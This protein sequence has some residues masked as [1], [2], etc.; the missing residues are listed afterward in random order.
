V[1]GFGDQVSEFIKVMG[2]GLGVLV[3][4][5]DKLQLSVQPAAVFCHAQV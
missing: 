3:D 2:L 5:L 1:T 4:R